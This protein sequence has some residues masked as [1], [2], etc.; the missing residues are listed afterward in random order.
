MI[1]TYQSRLLTTRRL[2]SETIWQ[3]FQTLELQDRPAAPDISES[4][5]VLCQQCSVLS[6][7]SLSLLMAHSFC[8]SGDTEA[9]ER[10]LRHEQAYR[11][12]AESWLNVLSVEYPF[13]E[14]YPL[15]SAHVLRP[16]CLTSAS[17]GQ[18]WVLDFARTK[19]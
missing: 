19:L 14:L 9:A 18:T 2:W 12:H 8:V 5:S 11:A 16:L 6:D 17:E 1:D 10:I 3:R 15:F 4:L 13:P 7:E